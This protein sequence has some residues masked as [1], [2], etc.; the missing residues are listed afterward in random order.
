MYY[1]NKI[2]GWVMSP[3]GMFFLSLGLAWVLKR[4]KWQRTAM[5]VTIASLALLWAFSC[6][7][8]TWIIGLP[9]ERMS[10]AESCVLDM[11]NIPEADAIVLLGGGISV[12]EECGS[13]EMMAG[14]DRVFVAARLWKAGKAKTLTLSGHGVEK[15]TLPLLKEFGVDEK[16]CVFFADARNT[17]EE[18]KMIKDLGAKKILLVTSAWHM[19]RAR[20]MFERRGFEVI[21]C[22]ADFEAH[23][24][25]ERPLEFGDFFPNGDSLNRN[26]YLFKEW[27][28]L[29]GYWITGR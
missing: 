11:D 10:G 27:I 4:R 9:L 13:L 15:S 2:I 22:P 25:W 5:G 1:V 14:S 19:P 26:S 28:G 20:M 8:M 12:H 3:L 21:A 29:L 7:W 23:C 6:S 16:A 24:T 17:E 18:S